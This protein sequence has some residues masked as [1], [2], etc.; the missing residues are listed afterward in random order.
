M[1]LVGLFDL[2]LLLFQV[3]D[4]VVPEDVHLEFSFADLAYN[5]LD[6]GVP[7]EFLIIPIVLGLI[8]LLRGRLCGELTLLLSTVF[9][10]FVQT[11]ST[12]DLVSIG[13]E[14]RIA[15]LILK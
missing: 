8:S 9:A 15:E 6:Q 14:T 5:T 3:R 2:F 7:V 1:I 11:E 13:L 4:I 12:L 10:R